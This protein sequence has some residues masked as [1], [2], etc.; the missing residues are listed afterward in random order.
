MTPLILASTSP[1]R[2]ELIEKLG[3]PF[4][5][6]KPICDEDAAKLRIKDPLLLATN[7]AREK[8]LSLATD[9]NC[10]IGGDQVVCLGNEILGKPGSF[11]KACEQLQKM[12]GKPHQLMT[13]LCVIFK[14]REFPILDVTEIR[15]RKLSSQQIENYVKRDQPLDCAGSYKIE[16]SA[17]TLIESLQ[18]QDFS[19]VQGVPLIGLTKILSDLGYTIPGD[20]G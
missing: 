10:V 5:V 14:L 9:Q 20:H 17:L 4:S 13:A 18:C 15:M 8:A 12:Q 11:T 6:S 1:Y 19:A 7:L 16:K 2:K 3:L